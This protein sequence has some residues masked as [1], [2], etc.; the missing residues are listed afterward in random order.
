MRLKLLFIGRSSCGSVAHPH[1]TQELEMVAHYFPD[2]VPDAPQPAFH[3]NIIYAHVMKL[4]SFV[5][6]MPPATASLVAVVPCRL[7]AVLTSCALV[8]HA[9]RRRT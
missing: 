3:V 5:R 6:P 2:P 7:P 9:C 1:A 4:L 8:P